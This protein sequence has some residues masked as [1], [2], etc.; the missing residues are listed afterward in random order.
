MTRLK[1]FTGWLEFAE[2]KLPETVKAPDYLD[3]FGYFFWMVQSQHIFV[4]S[5]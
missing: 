1:K 3:F 2:N 5:E 4:I